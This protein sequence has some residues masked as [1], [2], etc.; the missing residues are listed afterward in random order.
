MIERPLSPKRRVSYLIGG[1]LLIV[2]VIAMVIL[3]WMRVPTE[4]QFIR[5]LGLIGAVGCGGLGAVMIWIAKA[6][7][8]HRRR[9]NDAFL[10]L[11]VFIIGGI[12]SLFLN[13]GWSSGDSRMVVTGQI[14]LALLGITV[15]LH[16]GEQTYLSMQQKLET[17][18]SRLTEIAAKLDREPPHGP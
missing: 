14:L 9:H 17:L 7:V 6:G 12:G 5:V 16:I 2:F 4:V 18:E 11:A 8:F 1:S 13:Q 15:L 3:V 10:V